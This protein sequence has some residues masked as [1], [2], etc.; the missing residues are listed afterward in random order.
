MK[1]YNLIKNMSNFNLRL[2][3]VKRVEETNISETSRYYGM[4]RK[5]VRKWV[6]RY[7]EE[8]LKGLEDRSRAPKHIPHKLN[9]EEEARIVEL[10]KRHPAWGSRRLIERY[11][12]KGSH[13]A[14]NR[15]IKQNG[16]MRIKKNDGGN[17][18][19]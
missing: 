9:K 2:Q 1:Y 3:I 15:V 14:V 16:L 4:T 5:I 6:K 11:H 12:V 7:K 8:G 10:R 17:E 18:R 19:I 13:S